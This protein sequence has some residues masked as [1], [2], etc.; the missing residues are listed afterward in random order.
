MPSMSF[1]LRSLRLHIVH[2]IFALD[3]MVCGLHF[4]QELAE[5]A[6]EPPQD[7]VGRLGLLKADNA[8]RAVNAGVHSV[9]CHHVRQLFLCLLSLQAHQL[10]QAHEADLGVAGGQ[11]TDVLRSEAIADKSRQSKR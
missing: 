4:R 10:A 5:V 7:L 6:G 11:H 3:E 1:H 8:L 2:H 9:G